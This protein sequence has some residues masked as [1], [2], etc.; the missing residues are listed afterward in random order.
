MAN[1]SIQFDTD[2]ALKA[3]ATALF[4][5]LRVDMSTALN[6]FLKQCVATGSLPLGTEFSTFFYNITISNT[7]CYYYFTN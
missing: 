6:M 4:S 5:Q 7:F 2:S 1:V 3:Q